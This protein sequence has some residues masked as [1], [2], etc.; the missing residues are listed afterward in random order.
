MNAA[1]RA[2]RVHGITVFSSAAAATTDLMKR[3]FFMRGLLLD[4]FGRLAF[5]NDRYDGAIGLVFGRRME[6]EI[7]AQ[8]I[9]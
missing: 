2:P 1:R 9:G 8:K 6:F 7:N 3:V 5:V 4:I